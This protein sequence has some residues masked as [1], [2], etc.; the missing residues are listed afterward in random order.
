M[1][2]HTSGL[3]KSYTVISKIRL[4]FAIRPM[5]KLCF[6][7]TAV[8]QVKTVASVLHRVGTRLDLVSLPQVTLHIRSVSEAASSF[9]NVS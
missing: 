3:Q 9:L 2:S 5:K 7:E 4:G 1:D 6:S 8:S